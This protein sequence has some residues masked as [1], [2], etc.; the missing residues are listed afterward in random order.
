MS[1]WNLADDDGGLQRL[2]ITGET[3][4]KLQKGN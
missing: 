1:Y 2:H 3:Q 4:I